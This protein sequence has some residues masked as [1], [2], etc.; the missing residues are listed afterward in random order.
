MFYK[1]YGLKVSN[2]ITDKEAKS[3]NLE[4]LMKVHEDY[5]KFPTHFRYWNVLRILELAETL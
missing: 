5:F 1:E 4:R 2:K 3:K